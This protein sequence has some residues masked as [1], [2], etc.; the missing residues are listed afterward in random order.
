M[1]KIES[2]KRGIV[3]STVFNVFNKG[4][5]FING[6]VVAS[7]FGASGSTDFFFYVFN[8]LLILSAFC[9]NMNSSVIIPESMR[10]RAEEGEANA[11]RFLNFF[12]TLYSL[13]TAAAIICISLSPLRFFAAVS[14][15][16]AKQLHDQTSLL[17]LSLPLFGMIG[18]ITLLIDIIT[19]YK[20]FTISMTVGI[21]NGLT[22]I[23]LIVLLNKSMGVSSAFIGLIVSYTINLIILVRILHKNLN[24]KFSKR[25]NNIP[26]RIWNN[27]GF[28]QLGNLASALAQYMPIYILSGFNAGIITALTFAQQISALPNA[29]ITTQF[30]SVAGIKL[31]ELYANSQQGEV[32]RIFNEAANFLH[33]VM[34]P[35]S[36]VIFLYSREIVDIL[37]HLTTINQSTAAYM[38]TFMKYLGLLLPFYVSNTLISR[39]FM[40]SHKIKEAF[41]YQF[42]LNLILAAA[43]FMAV[44]EFGVIGYP[45]T[46]VSVYFVSTL[47]FYVIEKYYFDLVGYGNILKQF[48]L[49][50]LVNAAISVVI[51]FI[52]KS[53]SISWSWLVL[54][55][56][57]FLHISTLLLVNR[58][59]HLD[60]SVANNIAALTS[61]MAVILSL[62]KQ[63]I[64]NGI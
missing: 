35:L 16:D 62:K 40:A 52:I 22:S 46:L 3:L 14:E 60:R 61:R 64:E 45:L 33:F 51:Y 4:L 11:M 38:A 17:Y 5:V 29:L 24:W 49:I 36:F 13:I 6:I 7:Y 59:T 2:Y 48:F 8:S 31:N 53:M 39:L 23:L 1:F 32:R 50:V 58:L 54:F 20:F 63:K 41:R 28:A 15:F 47:L 30:S 12:I 18:V 26:R 27:L 25:I 10:I 43:T 44:K 19:S 56:G 37:V 57:T 9:M 21:L 34:I 42:A 55:L